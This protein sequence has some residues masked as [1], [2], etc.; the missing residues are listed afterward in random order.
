MSSAKTPNDSND[1]VEW[2]EETKSRKRLIKTIGYVAGPKTIERPDFQ[3]EVVESDGLE[4]IIDSREKVVKTLN[5]TNLLNGLV[6]D[7]YL[8]KEKQ[9]GQDPIVLD[10]NYDEDRD[11]YEVAPFGAPSKLRSIAYDVLDRNDLP[12]DTLEGVDTNDFNAVLDAVNDAVGRKVLV[13]VSEASQY[14][15]REEALSIAS[16]KVSDAKE[17]S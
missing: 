6:E 10:L 4:E 2:A 14:R 17:S 15:L 16:K 13:V 8:R 1:P 11:T 3:D 12:S 9:G 5:Q 7:G